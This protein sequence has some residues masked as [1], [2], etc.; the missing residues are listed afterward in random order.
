M[1]LVYRLSFF[2]LGILLLFGLPRCSL[3]GMITIDGNLLNESVATPARLAG[4]ETFDLPFAASMPDLGMLSGSVHI[5]N[6][7]AT[8]GVIRLLD[9]QFQSL[10]PRGAGDISFRLDVDQEFAYAGPPQVDGAF[11]LSGSTTF[12]AFPQSASGFVAGF[13]VI[14]TLDPL[15]FAFAADPQ[16]SF[17]QTQAF[18]TTGGIPGLPARDTMRLSLILSLVLSDNALSSGPRFESPGG[19]GE[20]AS[21]GY[22]SPSPVPEPATAT[23]LGVS[24]L[25]LLG[26]AW[27]RRR[28]V[29]SALS[30]LQ[31]LTHLNQEH[32]GRFDSCQG[33][34]DRVQV[35]FALQI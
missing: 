31:P 20:F 19:S 9:L 29:L 14:A 1:S 28:M 10:R 35:D 2:V 34:L 5:G 33:V 16:A 11:S 22:T 4:G 7:A 21:I 15:P 26:Y 30:F 13:L 8:A 18:G 24:A 25:A 17:P 6:E 32:P 23:L 27:P 3:A 12:T